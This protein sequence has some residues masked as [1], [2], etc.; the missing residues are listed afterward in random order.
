MRKLNDAFVQLQLDPKDVALVTDI[1]CIGLA[2]MLF[3]PLHTV[4]TT[5]GRSS[6]FATGIQVADA[7]L[8]DGKLKTIV[9]LGDGGAMIG[10]QHLINAALMNADI[11]VLVC[12]NFLFGMTGGQH[13]AFSPVDF[14]TPTTPSGNLIPPLDICNVLRSS[15]AGYAARMVATDKELAHTIAEAI[16][17][18]GFAVVEILELCTEHAVEKN[19][20]TGNSLRTIAE[21]QGHQ[22]GL[23]ENNQRRLSFGSAYRQKYQSALDRKTVSIEAEFTSNLKRRTGIVLAGSAGERVQSTAYRLCKGALRSGLYATQKNDNPVTQ[24]SGFSVSEVMLS[25]NPIHFTGITSPDVLIVSSKEGLM[26]C[27]DYGIYDAL[28]ERAEVIADSSLEL[29]AT[30]AKVTQNPFR[31]EGGNEHA[32]FAALKYYVSRSLLYP[33]EAL[34]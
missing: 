12:N 7:I 9:I 31:K 13:S 32:T 1:G 26:Y 25:P 8:Y 15:N 2:D 22:L 20:L 29:P 4:H 30:T 23:L 28:T 17:H 16:R 3:E 18:P 5:H 24:G 10:I 19:H 6:A 11:T 34:T 27:I 21:Q 33:P 14:V